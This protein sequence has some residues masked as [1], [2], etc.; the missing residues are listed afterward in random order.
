MIE[1]FHYHS[2]KY[3]PNT[4]SPINHEMPKVFPYKALFNKM[5]TQTLLPFINHKMSLTSATASEAK[6]R[7]R[8]LSQYRILHKC[9][10]I[11]SRIQRYARVNNEYPQVSFERRARARSAMTQFPTN[12]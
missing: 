11:S 6:R 3:L 12:F 4:T 7:K 8:S 2:T 9:H 5:F 10:D 1:L